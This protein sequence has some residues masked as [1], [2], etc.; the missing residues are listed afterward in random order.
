MSNGTFGPLWTETAQTSLCITKAHPYSFDPIKPHFY[1]LKLGFT[2][3]YIN[4]LISVQKYRLWVL[5]RTASKKYSQSVLSR[6][7]KYQ[8]FSSEIFHFF[9]IKFSVYLNRSVSVM[10]SSHFDLDIHF[11][12]WNLFS[13]GLL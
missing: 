8:N 13:G 4:F 3:V 2:G 12:L 6:N 9:G 10:I 1:T 11:S 7:M 5:V